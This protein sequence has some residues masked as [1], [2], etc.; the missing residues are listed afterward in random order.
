MLKEDWIVRNWA[1]LSARRIKEFPVDRATR[2]FR[3]SQAPLAGKF[4]GTED[5]FNRYYSNYGS[6]GNTGTRR[7]FLRPYI[8]AP[9]PENRIKA[10]YIDSKKYRID[11]DGI[12]RGLDTLYELPI[13]IFVE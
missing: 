3:E 9:M 8:G 6:I 11:D 4:Y 7:L 12:I 1:F 2:L 10:V 13:Y 5:F